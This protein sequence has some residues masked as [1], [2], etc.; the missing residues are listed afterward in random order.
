MKIATII[1]SRLESTRIPYKCMYKINDKPILQHLLNRL[2]KTGIDTVLAI[3]YSDAIEYTKLNLKKDLF[4]GSDEDPLERMYQCARA[5]KLD[6]V[7]RVTHD[8]ILVD[9]N[10]ILNAVKIFKERDLDYVYSTDFTDG[11]AFEIISFKN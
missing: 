2:D 1:C 8:K 9:P 11:S 3:P 6:A 7:I 4:I 5:H 10:T